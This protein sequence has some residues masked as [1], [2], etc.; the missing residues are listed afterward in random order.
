MTIFQLK[1]NTQGSK[2]FSSKK[3]H[4]R[5]INFNF[6]LMHYFS[7]LVIQYKRECI[8]WTFWPFHEYIWNC[9]HLLS[10][11]VLCSDYGFTYL[12]FQFHVHESTSKIHTGYNLICINM[13]H[14]LHHFWAHNGSKPGCTEGKVICVSFTLIP[15]NRDNRTNR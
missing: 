5:C 1:Q 9:L 11:E 4:H 13:Q 7:S 10:L 6:I 2:A 14:W 15:D 12:S 3:S 8:S